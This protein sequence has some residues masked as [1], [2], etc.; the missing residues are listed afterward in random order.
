VAVRWWS[1]FNAHGGQVGLGVGFYSVT[2]WLS[3][4]VSA[5]PE[6]IANVS[7]SRTKPIELLEDVDL[8][9]WNGNHTPPPMFCF[10]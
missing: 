8:C 4:I 10:C 2:T 7:T 9:A 6:S 5:T 3:I 1:V